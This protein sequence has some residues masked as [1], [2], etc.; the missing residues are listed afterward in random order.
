MSPSSD[1]SAVE[2]MGLG[3]ILGLRQSQLKLTGLKG[4]ACCGQI[5]QQ[6]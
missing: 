3:K 2:G 1:H 6:G 5:R 4:N